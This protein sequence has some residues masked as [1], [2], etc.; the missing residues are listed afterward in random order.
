MEI[1]QT[2]YLLQ[3]PVPQFH[4]LAISQTLEKIVKLLMTAEEST[5]EEELLPVPWTFMAPN[6]T[7]FRVPKKFC[8]CVSPLGGYN[9]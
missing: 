6:I 2:N 4:I 7:R 5:F 9:L 8:W 1:Q 3:A